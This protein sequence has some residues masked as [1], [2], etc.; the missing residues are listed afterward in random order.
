V[1]EDGSKRHDTILRLT[2]FGA[3]DHLLAR[4]P[5]IDLKSPVT[6]WLL[7]HGETHKTKRVRLFTVF[8]PHCLAAHTP[9]LAGRVHT[10][11]LTSRAKRHKWAKQL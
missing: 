1:V 8:I 3:A 9:L 2:R 4:A 7:T 11:R 6:I 10:A 5:G